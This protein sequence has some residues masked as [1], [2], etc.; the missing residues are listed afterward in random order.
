MLAG[1]MINPTHTALFV[2][3]AIIIYAV[4]FVA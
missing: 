2:L 3:A 1:F 4:F